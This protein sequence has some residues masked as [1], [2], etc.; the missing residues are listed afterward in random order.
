MMGPAMKVYCVAQEYWF[1]RRNHCSC[2]GTFDTV[3]QFLGSGA[4]GPVDVI[5]TCCK[6]CGAERTFIFDIS[7]FYTAFHDSMRL[8]K[9]ASKLKDEH[10]REKLSKCIGTPMEV[11]LRFIAALAE[12]KDGLAI[13]YL[14]DVIRFAKQQ[15]TQ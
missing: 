10:L 9:L 11:T 7:E 13:E 5:E 4:E 12:A 8:A 6:S 14:E 2:G 3:T 15:V 1:I